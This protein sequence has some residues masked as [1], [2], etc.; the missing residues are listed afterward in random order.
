MD[1]RLDLTAYRCPL[2]LLMTKKALRSLAQGERLS[3]LLEE[4]SVADFHLLAEQLGFDCRECPLTS[5]GILLEF[6]VV[7][8]G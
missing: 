2:P 5:G 4:G 6:Y 7:S 3:V 8:K 1:Y